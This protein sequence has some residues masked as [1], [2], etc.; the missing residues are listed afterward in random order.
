MSKKRTTKKRRPCAK[1]WFA[2]DADGNPQP[3]RGTFTP[4]WNA[5]QYPFAIRAEYRLVPVR[6]A[7]R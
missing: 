5:K 3:D 4:E 1:G 2:L 6:K 7:K